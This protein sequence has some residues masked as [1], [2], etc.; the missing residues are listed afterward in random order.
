MNFYWITLSYCPG[1]CLGSPLN[2][3]EKSFVYVF[4]NRG[5]G[6]SLPER[7]V[8]KLLETDVNAIPLQPLGMPKMREWTQINLDKSDESTGY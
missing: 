3:W 8:I 2:T 4:M 6:V 5:G 7:S 1:R